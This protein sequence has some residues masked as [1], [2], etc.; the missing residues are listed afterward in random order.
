MET[1]LHDLRY[2]IRQLRRSPGFT[3]VAVLTLALGIG[4]TTTIFSAVNALLLESLPYPDRDRLVQ[5]GQ[6]RENGEEWSQ[7]SAASYLAL[8][9]QS[10]EFESLAAFHWWGVNLG[11]KEGA[12]RVTGFQASPDFFTT[13]GARPLLGRT[14]APGEGEPGRDGVVVLSQELWRNRFAVD[15]A[16]LGET[17]TLNGDPHTVI[18]V[19]PSRQ[20]FPPHAE[21]WVPR[22]FRSDHGASLYVVGRL[23][24]GVTAEQAEA[25][26]SALLRRLAQDA[27]QIHSGTGI[28]LHSFYSEQ[29]EYL[30]TYLGIL[31]AAVG[32]V[33]LIACAN[34]ANL[35]LARA[36]GR[37][38]E[39]AVRTA[40]GA[41]RGRIVRQL[42]TESLLLAL[43]GGI[44]GMLFAFW[45]V[46]MLQRSIPADL[47][48]F[49]SGWS[50]LG[51]DG[52]VLGFSLA[53]S[54][55]AGV[56]FGLFP[57]LGAYRR[58]PIHALREG[59]R[60][61]TGVGSGRLRRTLVVA[62]V[63]LA[64]VLLIGAGLMVRS[65]VGL[66]RADPGFRTDHLLT[67]QVSL[68]PGEYQDDR[69]TL[70][71]DQ[72][73]ERV[74]GLPGVMSTGLVNY[75]PMSRSGSR[76]SFTVEGRSAPA[77]GEDPSAQYRQVTPGYLETMG[78]P[79]LRGR[80]FDG[81]ES[82]DGPGVVLV[83][84]TLA[85]L[86]FPGTNPVGGRVQLWDQTWEI[87]G[88][89][90]DVHHWGLAEAPSPEIYLSQSQAPSQ[91]AF[92]VV[93]AQ[94]D[95][96]DLIPAIRRQI[97]AL[98]PGV[99]IDQP[100]SMREVVADFTSPERLMS[101]L[102]GIFALIALLIAA[103]GI[104]G[105]MAHMVSQRTHEI[106]VRMALGAEPGRVRRLVMR[107]GLALAVIGLAIGLAAAFVLS[108]FLASML[109]GVDAGDPATFLVVAL[110]LAAVSLVAAWLPARRATRVD[111][112]IALRAE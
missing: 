17:I 108:P 75:L 36:S 20:A 30:T 109:Y 43:L 11:G 8:R 24:P 1:L 53:I 40:I 86:Y 42:L 52:R 77:P 107:Q 10:P 81:H 71:Q 106:G 50:E 33:L 84:E 55:F 48:H 12:E 35:M 60:G 66:L 41:G 13:L 16:V 74:H 69:T 34:I 6:L 97:A 94:G 5:F 72:L 78:I 19:M 110:L 57:A 88:V 54:L 51:V 26:L 70:L 7:L 112:L 89:V 23:E 47:A 82:A 29:I 4:A 49:V 80:G 76:I 38:R 101:S 28:L 37:S 61:G 56:L 2:S 67:L 103:I 83:N 45:S 96:G 63:A 102:L 22:E 9:D 99:A 31:F 3:A 44:L 90:S 104:Y 39:I 73:L 93:R 105:V 32:F 59:A 27:P 68:P 25:R 64:L 111:P 14:F 95:P 62:E 79:L 65:F 100:R 58:D 15:P 92:L 46:E 21:L 85:R 91:A 98:D 18:G 87:V